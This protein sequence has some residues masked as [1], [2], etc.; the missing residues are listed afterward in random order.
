MR[1]ARSADLRQLLAR[2]APVKADKGIAHRHPRFRSQ[3]G[4]ADFYSRDPNSARR[5]CQE[6]CGHSSF[7][8][9]KGGVSV[10]NM[11]SGRD[12]A[13]TDQA[14]VSESYRSPGYGQ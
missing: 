13:P 2:P 1:T 7:A 9:S 8:C 3:E 6:R 14:C 11:G 10:A 4:G 12:I 5:H